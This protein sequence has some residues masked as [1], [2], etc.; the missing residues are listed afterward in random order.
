MRLVSSAAK[1]TCAPALLRGAN[2]EGPDPPNPPLVRGGGCLRAGDR[3][4]RG[5]NIEG[6]NPLG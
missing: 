3:R 1:G 2:I 6:R 4:L 5:E